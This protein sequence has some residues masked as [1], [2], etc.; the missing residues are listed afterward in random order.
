MLDGVRG[1]AILMVLILHFLGDAPGR[2]WIEHVVVRAVSYGC[3]GV[4]LF[5]ILS[6][7][8]I[9][10]VL[11]DSRSDPKYF[12][13][14]YMRRA[15]RIFPV[16]YSVLVLVFVVAPMVPTLSGPDLDNLV[17][18]Q[19]WAWLYS[20][21]F[22]IALQGD[23]TFS[24]LNHF[25]SLSIEEQFYLLWAPAVFALAPKP[26]VL[27]QTCIAV[28][29]GSSAMRLVGSFMGLGWWTIYAMTPFR[30]DGLAI[31][32]FLAVTMRQPGGSGRL[33]RAL[34]STV[35]V[36]GSLLALTFILPHRSLD[37][38]FPL[39]LSLRVTLITLLL[40]CLLVRAVLAPGHAI[41]SRFFRS[42][43]MVVLGTYSYGL[44]VY[45][46]FISYYLASHG[47]A[48]GISSSVGSYWLALAVQAVLGA[49]ASLA[50]AYVSYEFFEKRFLRLK[51]MFH[52]E[53]HPRL[54]QVAAGLEH[55][56]LNEHRRPGQAVASA[57]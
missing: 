49:S 1:L 53:C 8:L 15:L 40:A 35:A 30:L 12:R 45:H 6:G 42:R 25:W 44:Y 31:G 19:A 4:D 52:A 34:P 22:Y 32:A 51:T 50:L 41:I 28:A 11:Y 13:N 46:H 2:N 37:E 26:R 3:Y 9:T 29:L 36:L 24:Y 48:A 55:G 17:N 16:Y 18:R 33:A 21:N 39:A 7:F 54:P 57:D 43:V 27:L 56:L 47:V 23:W 5:F 10:G 38:E 20:V 14:F